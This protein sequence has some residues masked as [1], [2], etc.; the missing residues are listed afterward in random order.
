MLELVRVSK[1]SADQR[2]G[3]AGRISSGHCI[4]LYGEEDLTRANIEPEILRSSLDR[5]V[6]Q[7]KRINFDPT[8]FPF[9]AQPDKR[10]IREALEMLR[11]IDCLTDQGMITPR[12]KLFVDLPFD[13]RLCQF[14]LLAAEKGCAEAALGTTMSIT[15]MVASV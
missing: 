4:R 2:M 6:L 3:R 9:I 12:G 7:L 10:F 11:N 5:T 15:C 14:I 8:T 13:P 1:S